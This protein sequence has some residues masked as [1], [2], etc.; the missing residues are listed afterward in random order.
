MRSL[1]RVV[2]AAAKLED[3]TVLAKAKWK[4]SDA[5]RCV[6]RAEKV[7]L[8]MIDAGCAPHPDPQ[9]ALRA[10]ECRALSDAAQKLAR[11]GR[12]PQEIMQRLSGKASALSAAA[13]TAERATL[14]YVEQQCKD[15]RA[16]LS[17]TAVQFQC[18]L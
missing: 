12:V 8:A 2:P 3:V 14:P 9:I 7:E 17:G 18:Q 16:E 5:A 10:V 11:C 6:A 4:K 13:Q 15:A 1:A